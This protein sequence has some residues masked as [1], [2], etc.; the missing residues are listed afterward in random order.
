MEHIGVLDAEELALFAR[1]AFERKDLEKALIYVKLAMEQSEFPPL[2]HALAGKIYAQ[3]GLFARAVTSLATYLE[4]CPADYHVRCQ[5]GLALFR[6]GNEGEALEAW[7]GALQHNATHPPAL[8]FAAYVQAARQS[9]ADAQRLIDILLTS[10]GDENLFSI[11]AQ[12]LREWINAANSGV[13]QDALAWPRDLKD[14]LV[15][16]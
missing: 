7:N 15:F 3:M 9:W 11:K 10:A 1:R 16:G 8:F 4:L 5:L 14:D 13:G 12:Q 6:L 2:C